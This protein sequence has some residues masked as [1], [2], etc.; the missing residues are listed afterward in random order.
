MSFIS[1]CVSFWSRL[2]PAGKWFLIG[3]GGFL[4]GFGQA[5]VV[6]NGAAPCTLAWDASPDERIA[7]YA[8]YY[9]PDDAATTNRL[10]AGAAQAVTIYS[11]TVA[12]NYF[13]YV[14]AYNS[15]RVESCPSQVI[16]YRP[17]A[18]SALRLSVQTDGS[19]SLQFRA[20]PGA[21]CIVQYTASLLDPQWSTLSTATADADG[22]V[23]IIDPLGKRPPARYYRAVR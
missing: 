2:L 1:R 5:A 16:F 23:T 11:L 3:L 18:L 13:F 20:A 6:A 12:S 15:N 4:P 22:V 21:V 19:L 17:S 9:G 7:G 10:D 8:V 14:V